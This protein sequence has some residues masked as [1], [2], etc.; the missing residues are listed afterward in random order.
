MK[1]NLLTLAM[2][3]GLTGCSMIPQ[4]QQP[5]APYAASWEQQAASSAQVP[6]W[7]LFFRDNNLQQ[8][9]RTALEHN[10]DL[11]VA[12]LNAEAFRAQYRIQRSE[13]FPSIDASG[14]GTHQR[15]PRKVSQTG[16]AQ[17]THQYS[18]AVGMNAW[19]LDFFGRIR[20]LKDQALQNYFASAQAQR[21]AE[22]SLVA[23]V[24]TAW[25]TLQADQASLQLA[26]ATLQTYE[27]SQR[28]T[29]LS[30]DAGIAS[31]LELQQSRTA[32]DG[33]R[34]TLAQNQRQLAQSRN[35]LQLVLG[36]PLPDQL[37]PSGKLDN[38]SLADLPV[39]LPSELLQRRPDI[40]QAEHQLQAAN[41]NIGAARAAFFPSISLT[42]TAGSLSGELSDLFGSGTGTWLFQP[43]INLPIFNSGRLKANLEYSEIQKDIHV[44]QYEKAIQTAFQEVADGLVARK[45]YA[46]QL[47]AQEQLLVS[48]QT[49]LDLAD[50]RYREGID[51]QL[52]LLDAQ[53]L[54][55]N[56]RQQHIN[57][58]L[59]RLV[60]EV[61][62]FKALGGG[63]DNEAAPPQVN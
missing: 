46:D 27:D 60:S 26:E 49:Y 15:V 37:A 22:L 9:I 28:L 29:E 6:E 42:A 40:M 3:A 38:H 58:Q 4:Y 13:L 12:A 44:A 57:V 63:F 41:A 35:A 11:R 25:F 10:R 56:T 16:D 7:Q 24:A 5:V 45:T 48:S 53:R 61:N 18:A 55:F 54:N 51:N 36:A 30:H 2:L 21:S 1:Y 31:A 19:E 8:L 47:A 32:T 59:A 17:T 39:L 23:N 20:S 62:L 43:Q 14:A 52:T 50:R 33:A 34:V